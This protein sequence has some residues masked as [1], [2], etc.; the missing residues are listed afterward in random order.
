MI[1]FERVFWLIISTNACYC[2]IQNFEIVS[3]CPKMMLQNYTYYIIESQQNKKLNYDWLPVS[4]SSIFY[5]KI[6]HWYFGAQNY[7]AET[8]LEKAVQSTFVQKNSQVKC[9]WNRPQEFVF[10]ISRRT[11][12]DENT[13]GHATV[14]EEMVKY[15]YY[16]FIEVNKSFRTIQ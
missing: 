14:T 11:I 12:C 16:L 7:K 8:Y 10:V 1:W 9:W 5:W 15:W 13:S 2:I 6:L 3:T 4:I